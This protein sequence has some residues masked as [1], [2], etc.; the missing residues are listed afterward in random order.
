MLRLPHCTLWH[1]PNIESQHLDWESWSWWPRIHG[2]A[3]WCNQKSLMVLNNLSDIHKSFNK[4]R[5]KK[6]KRPRLPEVFP[7]EKQSKIE[8][9]TGQPTTPP[10]NEPPQKQGFKG[11]QWIGGVNDISKLQS[12]KIAPR[13]PPPWSDTSCSSMKAKE[14]SLLIFPLVN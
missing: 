5:K 7:P 10:P 9:M 14:V 12:I 6:Q 8:K 11:N 2:E 3:L 1:Q 4:Q 13:Q